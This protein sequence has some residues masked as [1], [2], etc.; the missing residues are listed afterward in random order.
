MFGVKQLERP[1]KVKKLRL[2]LGTDSEYSFRSV[3]QC[4]LWCPK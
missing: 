1:V 3:A 2:S 4:E